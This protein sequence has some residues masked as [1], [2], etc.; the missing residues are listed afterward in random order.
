VPFD[1]KEKSI[2][3]CKERLVYIDKRYTGNSYCLW[4]SCQI[5]D[6]EEKYLINSLLSL[7]YFL[8]FLIRNEG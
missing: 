4:F 2:V 3:K 8:E 7:D 6:Q 5:Q 1:I